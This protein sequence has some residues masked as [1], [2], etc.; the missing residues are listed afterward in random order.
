MCGSSKSLSQ[1]YLLLIT[2]Y[3]LIL[4]APRP[5]PFVWTLKVFLDYAEKFRTYVA[6]VS[7]CKACQ[8]AFLEYKKDEVSWL[9]LF[10]YA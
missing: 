9:A 5:P 2:Y 4:A 7:Q 3:Y 10:I 6:Y 1:V 8:T